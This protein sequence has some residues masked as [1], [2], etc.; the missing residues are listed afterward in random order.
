MPKTY[1]RRRGIEVDEFVEIKGNKCPENDGEINDRVIE[2]GSFKEALDY[3]MNYVINSP[4]ENSIIISGN[5]GSG[6]RTLIRLVQYKTKLITVYLDPTIFQTDVSAINHVLHKIGL[7]SRDSLSDTMNEIERKQLYVREKIV[8]VL[9]D[10]DQFCRSKQSLLYNLTQ[11]IQFGLNLC[12]IGL[13]MSRD[14]IE[15]LEKRVRSRL[16]ASFYELNYPYRSLEEYVEFASSLLGGF[17]FSEEIERELR[18]RY[19]MKS[20]SIPSL[21]WHLLNICRWNRKRLSVL[22]AAERS[23]CEW[24]TLLEAVFSWLTVS[25]LEVLMAITRYCKRHNSHHF[26]LGPLRRWVSSHTKL[27]DTR[28]ADWIY[29]VAK[30]RNLG[31][32]SARQRNRLS[33]DDFSQFYCN[34]TLEQFKDVWDKHDELRRLDVNDLWLRLR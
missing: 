32:I 16:N 28:S 30:L 18:A 22:E 14:C 33:I 15:N 13:T 17:K 23:G 24:G 1:L 21:R 7:K 34:V 6:K 29:N 27:L 25:Q 20:R 3:L 4:S 8:V 12:L 5:A 26:V 31:L 11:M 9:V 10:F 19:V 2:Y